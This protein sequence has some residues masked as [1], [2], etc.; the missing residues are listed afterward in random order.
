MKFNATKKTLDKV[1]K[2]QGVPLYKNGEKGKDMYILK[3]SPTCDQPDDEGD[4]VTISTS[5]EIYTYR[6]EEG[7][8]Q[9][10]KDWKKCR[11]KK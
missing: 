6:G 11:S 9:F 1:K 3:V 8:Q 5:K 7:L 10:L 2:L 4:M